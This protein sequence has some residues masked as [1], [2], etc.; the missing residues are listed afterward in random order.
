VNTIEFETPTVNNKADNWI[1]DY[2]MS[3]RDDGAYQ[4]FDNPYRVARGGSWHDNPGLCRSA[5]R[6]RFAEKDAE[7]FIGLRVVAISPR[8]EKIAI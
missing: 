8:I 4:M 5:A 3:P 6:I 7:E 2:R 1:D